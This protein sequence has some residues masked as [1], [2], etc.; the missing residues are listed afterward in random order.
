[1]KELADVIFTIPIGE[2]S[3]LVEAKNAFHLIRVDER[4]G[5]T[6]RPLSDA[7]GEIHTVL[8]EAVADSLAFRAAAGFLDAVEAGASFDSLAAASGGMVHSGPTQ[9]GEELPGIGAFETA[10]TAI[11]GIQDGAVTPEPVPVGSG[12]LVARRV[13][14]VAPAPAPFAEI[15]DRVIAAYQ[16]SQ[17]R[18]LADSMDQKL[19]EAI[20]RGGDVESLFDGMGGMRVSRAFPRTGPIPDFKDRE[21]RLASDSTLLERIFTSRPGKVLPPVKS[22]MGTIYMIVES[23]STPPAADFARRREEVWREI[24]DRRIEAWTARLR[25]RAQVV[26]YRKELKSLLA[27]G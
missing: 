16:M 13:R 19:R 24:V 5:D 22:S 17:R 12:Y 3:D 18:A 11:G 27:S 8:G 15:K 4:T 23:V 26:M 21:P 7:R 2:L 9:A 25:A 14:E 6:L 1:M 10:A 20:A